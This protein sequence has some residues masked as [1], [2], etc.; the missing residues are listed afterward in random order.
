L[1]AIN[2]LIDVIPNSEP[3]VCPICLTDYEL[4]SGVMLRQC[5]HS[6]CPDCLK[7][8]IIHST[9]IEVKCPSV[10]PNNRH[11]ESNLL[12]REIRAL[13][14]DT[15]H[16]KYLSRSLKVAESTI[17]NT[18]H[19]LTADCNGW[20]V[21]EDNVGE[22]LCGLCHKPNCLSCKVI[23]EG[24]TCDEY[25]KT[26]PAYK[27]IEANQLSAAVVEFMLKEGKAMKC[28][29]CEVSN[30]VCGEKFVISF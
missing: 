25:A 3:F 18:F 13:L 7:N 16:N 11:C 15:E 17:N 26:T 20:C 21:I 10:D 29:N 28:T 5:L 23:H 19:C 1:A 27:I 14:N 9:D 4:G 2:E 8:H 22:F 24:Q 6:F 30:S 12:P